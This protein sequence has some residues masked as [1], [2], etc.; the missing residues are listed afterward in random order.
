MMFYFDFFLVEDGVLNVLG[1]LAHLLLE[2]LVLAIVLLSVGVD[3]YDGR[4]LLAYLHR[5]FLAI[6]S[7]NNNIK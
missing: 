7:I 1:Q 4:R 3:L 6:V 5:Q 2:R